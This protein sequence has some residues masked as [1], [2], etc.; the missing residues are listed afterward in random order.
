MNSTYLLYIDCGRTIIAYSLTSMAPKYRV[1]DCNAHKLI[2]SPANN[3]VVMA[4]LLKRQ[5][6][7]GKDVPVL[8][9]ALVTICDFKT[10]FVTNSY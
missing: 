2:A 9:T 7:E 5:H 6:K 8:R 4:T 3:Y 1:P 10:R